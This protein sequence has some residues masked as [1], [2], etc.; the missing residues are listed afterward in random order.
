MWSSLDAALSL[1]ERIEAFFS[2]ELLHTR[3]AELA[4][5]GSL[6]DPQANEF[7]YAAAEEDPDPLI[8]IAAMVQLLRRETVDD[9]EPLL[10]LLADEAENPRVYSLGLM[11]I[12]ELPKPLLEH[13]V[14][15]LEGSIPDE[16]V[17]CAALIQLIRETHPE[18]LPP[19]LESCIDALGGD[20]ALDEEVWD[21][22]VVS[23]ASEASELTTVK[24]RVRG[25]LDKLADDHPRR[26]EFT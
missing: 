7:I 8:R 20:E 4:S 14:K 2:A 12:E 22:M 24:N 18:R 19:L 5:I 21:E 23:L 11:L 25:G 16:A 3:L 15:A 9:T 17:N 6:E 1:G 26:L 13:A 10:T